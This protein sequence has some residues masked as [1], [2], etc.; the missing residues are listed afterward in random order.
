MRGLA[1][2]REIVHVHRLAACA[3]GIQAAAGKPAPVIEHVA[4]G[5]TQNR[6]G[7]LVEAMEQERTALGPSG[8]RRRLHDLIAHGDGENAV[9]QRHDLL[10]LAPEY[11]RSLKQESASAK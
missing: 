7:Q 1:D 3:L 9:A 8:L 4:A 10:P 5:Q 6:W 11:F 2:L